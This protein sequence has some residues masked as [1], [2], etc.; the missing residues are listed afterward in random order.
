MFFPWSMMVQGSL[1]LVIAP[2]TTHK[3][4]TKIVT[5]GWTR[6]LRS[7]Q[8]NLGAMLKQP[9]FKFFSNKLITRTMKYP[10]VMIIK[11]SIAPA[12]TRILSK[13]K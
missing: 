13:V 2:F 8:N 7:P 1:L 4:H 5:L 3:K 12:T 6:T 10:M 9:T 11:W